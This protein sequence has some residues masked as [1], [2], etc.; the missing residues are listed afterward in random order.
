MEW[1]FVIYTLIVHEATHLQE[2][3][4]LNFNFMC[5]AKCCQTIFSNYLVSNLMKI[6]R[7]SYFEDLVECAVSRFRKT[8]LNMH[9]NTNR[10]SLN[11][12]LP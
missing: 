10:I 3:K 5:T 1:T 7:S 6:S 12:V 2:I 9:A 4:T 8:T 11:N